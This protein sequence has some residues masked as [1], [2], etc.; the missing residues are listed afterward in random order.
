MTA[1]HMAVCM[2]KHIKTTYAQVDIVHYSWYKFLKTQQKPQQKADKGRG[3]DSV[4][5]RLVVEL[6]VFQVALTVRF[7]IMP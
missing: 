2:W 1:Y 5:K 7:E 4:L 3:F 6:R